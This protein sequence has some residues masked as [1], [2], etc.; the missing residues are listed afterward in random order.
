V[1]EDIT[2]CS[3]IIRCEFCELEYVE[4]IMVFFFYETPSSFYA[5]ST[6]YK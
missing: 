6:C 4:E 5:A 1:I 2:Y 3:C